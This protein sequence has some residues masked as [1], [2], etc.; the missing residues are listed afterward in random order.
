MELLL[1]SYATTAQGLKRI[2]QLTR[3]TQAANHMRRMGKIFFGVSGD[4]I[5]FKCWVVQHSPV[6][7]LPSVFSCVSRSFYFVVTALTFH[8]ITRHAHLVSKE[9]VYHV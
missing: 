8:S 9:T 4:V 3:D 7:Y 1:L 2:G 5:V 6:F